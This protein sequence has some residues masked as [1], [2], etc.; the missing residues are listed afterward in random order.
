MDILI[1]AIAYPI[2]IVILFYFIFLRPVQMQQK[3]RRRDLNE[4][5]I[6]DEVLTQA[7]FIAIVKD[8]IVPENGPTEIMLEISTGVEVKAHASSI[9]QRITSGSQD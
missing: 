6:G 7:G 2:V 4:L 1:L 9:A 3:Q 5:S 8:I